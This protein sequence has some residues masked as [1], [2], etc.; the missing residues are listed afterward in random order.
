MENP[1]SIAFIGGGNMA[2][3]LAVGLADKVC[4]AH[5]IHVLDTNDQTHAAWLARGMTVASAPDAALSR[6]RVWI[7]AVKPQVMRDVVQA[8][9]P[10]L[11][12]DTLVISVAAGLRADTLAGWL[13]QPDQ[14]WGRLVRCMPNTPALV[15]QGMT[16]MAALDGVSAAD[17]QL[18]QTLLGAVGEVVW[19]ADDAALDA[20]TALSG[21][22][23]AYVFLFLESLIAA[24]QA[25]GLT[26]EQARQLALGTFAGATSLAR[27]AEEPPSVLR[28]RVTSKGGTTAAA[29][30]VF[31]QSDLR[32]IVAQA[33]EAAARRSQ[34]LGEEFGK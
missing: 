26:P 19:V 30:A 14:P 23:P 20:V 22:G 18:A 10:W 12:P 32:G 31:E 28:E 34:E 27:A 15:G 29:L 9:R 4:P 25:Q 11:E 16:G 5:N 6:C 1:L 21:S 3:A 33:V 24:G 17:R 13:G 7:F 8:V 2:S